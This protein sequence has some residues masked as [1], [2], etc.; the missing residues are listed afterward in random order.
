MRIGWVPYFGL[1]HCG[2]TNYGH[3][4]DAYT[5]IGYI[6]TDYGSMAIYLLGGAVAGA[7]ASHVLTMAI[8][9]LGGAV[10]GAHPCGAAR[11]QPCHRCPRPG[12]LS[13]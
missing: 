6:S 13:E 3:T 12:T 10:A 9:V 11:D 7:H 5:D 1:A 4:Y 8:H 2:C